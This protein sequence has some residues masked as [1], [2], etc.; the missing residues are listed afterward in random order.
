MTDP[1][2]VGESVPI[3]HPIA[4]TQVYILDRYLQPIPIGGPGELYI[5]GHG[6][7]RGYHNRPD[8]TADSF[9]PNPF[10]D[11]PGARLYKTGD[12]ARYLPDGNIE[13]LRRID[14]QVK[15]RG[16]RIESGEI[17]A[18]LRQ[19]SMVRETVVVA[20]EDGRGDK[21]LA[22]YVVPVRGESPTISDLRG[23]LRQRLPDYMVPSAFVM[24]DE[25]PLTPNGK[26]DRRALPP[27]DQIRLD[28]EQAFVA[29]RT[30]V[31]ETLASIW[32]QV[33]D[34]ER[35]GV[36]D[37]FFDL[38]GHSLLATQFVSRVRQEFKVE[39]PLVRLFESPTIA[40]LAD[41][42]DTEHQ[43]DGVSTHA[44]AESWSSLMAI[45]P[46]GTK[47]PFFLVPG[48]GGGEGEF[49]IYAQLTHLL[50]SDQPVYGLVARGLD[51]EQPP[52]TDVE[53]MATDYVQE[54]RA[55]Q[56]EGPY[57]LGGECTGGKVAYEMAQQLLAQGQQV[58][59]VLVSPPR[60]TN[61]ESLS[62][63]LHRHAADLLQVRRVEYHLR[64]LQQLPPRER[65]IYTLDRLRIGLSRLLPLS[66]DQ[67]VARRIRRVRANYRTTLRRHTPR[68]AYTGQMT[69]LVT[70]AGYRDDPT[71]G[72][73]EWAAGGLEIH[74]LPGDR[75]TYLG[76]HVQTAAAR[77]KAWL[78]AAQDE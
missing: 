4:N 12:L 7:A 29:P 17:E 43:T 5:G 39:L 13:F 51:R 38:G 78:E 1:D 71:M 21:S 52:H 10:S 19:H 11:E 63:N 2:D 57:L 27:P 9:I 33:L 54:I 41:H 56:S 73:R 25:L 28:L 14:H 31:E 30:P 46:S 24:L 69:L 36:Y 74:R 37:D 66:P 67:R 61:S 60:L 53:A 76:E 16:F 64:Q 48:G 18:V 70:E 55:L 59:L 42:I 32:A 44:S 34:I 35:I 50:G 72:W 65:L 20:R 77:L 26:V 45:R 3:G 68:N 40:G 47:P 6:V 75:Y 8:L 22:A 15:I 49:L 23:F 62:S 58:A